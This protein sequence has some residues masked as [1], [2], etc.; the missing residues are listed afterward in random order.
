MASSRRSRWASAVAMSSALTPS[1]SVRLRQQQARFQIGKPRRHHQIIGG[2]LQ[3]QF[4]RRL[5]EGEIL[6]GQRQDGDL[7][8]ID[9]LLARQR[10]QKVERTLKALDVDDQRG[11]VVAALRQLGSNGSNW[12]VSAIMRIPA[13]PARRRS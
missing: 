7:G 5:D 12:T 11:L 13:R 4:A 10:Q 6:V 8:E 2:E 9:L 3:P 1:G